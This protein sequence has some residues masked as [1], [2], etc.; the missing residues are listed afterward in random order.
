MMSPERDVASECQRL[1]LAAGR[2]RDVSPD[3]RAELAMR[4]AQSIGCEA[5]AW[6]RA[7]VAMK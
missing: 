2:W 6:V 7:A 1:S 4:T 3:E 5:G